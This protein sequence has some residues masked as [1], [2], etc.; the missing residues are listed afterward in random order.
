MGNNFHQGGFKL[1]TDSIRGLT[2]SN[3][4]V[5]Y[6]YLKVHDIQLIDGRDFS[7]DRPLDNGY[8]FIINESF[9]KEL[10]LDNPVGVAAGH[11]WYP[12]DSLGTI[13]G[14]VSDFNF[15]SLHYKVNTLA[16]VVHEEWGYEE[17]SVKIDGDQIEASIAEV[18]RVW[19]NLVPSWPFQYSFLDDHFEELYR[20]DQQ[21]ESV[22][23]LMAILAILIACMGLFGLA[24]IAT[25]K[26][27]KEIGIRKVL[28][29]S[30]QQIMVRL[31]MH[32]ALLVLVAFVVFSPI[33]YW[34][35][36]SWLE[37]FADHVPIGGSVFALGFLIAFTIA[38]L[39]VSYHTLRAALG[40]PAR[41]LRDD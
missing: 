19:N 29:A 38:I 39:T 41:A 30:V 17:L 34:L 7:K 32:F 11:S 37:N 18:E 23:S 13:I 40:D 15:N 2:P 9:A 21:M 36:K 5:D 28:G 10:N 8:G 24:A 22:V 1:R 12:D 16:I 6:D 20:S 31:S 25:E 3:L 26:R 14:V 27:I 35:I 4:H 33:T